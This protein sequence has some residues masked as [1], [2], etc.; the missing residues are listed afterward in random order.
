MYFRPTGITQVRKE[1]ESR[2]KAWALNNGYT[3]RSGLLQADDHYLTAR[4]AAD[5]K[6]IAE[7]RAYRTGAH[8]SDVD[9][10]FADAYKP[11]EVGD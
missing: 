2:L 3:W 5:G 9:V 11:L 7:K 10:N 6:F 4:Y 1:F 8:I